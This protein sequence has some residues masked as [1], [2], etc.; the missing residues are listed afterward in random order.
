MPSPQAAAFATAAL[1]EAMASKQNMHEGCGPAGQNCISHYSPCRTLGAIAATFPALT[2]HLGLHSEQIM[3]LLHCLVITFCCLLSC[4]SQDRCQ[5]LMRA[6]MC[7]CRWT[8]HSSPSSY[9]PSGA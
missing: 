7:T 1:A 6:P 5:A 3:V 9:Q 4:R 8:L 2:E